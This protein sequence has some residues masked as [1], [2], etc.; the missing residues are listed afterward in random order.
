MKIP[1]SPPYINNNVIKEIKEAL[2]SGWITTGPKVKK[3]EEL[4]CHYT[5]APNAL[6]VNS[7]TSGLMLALKWFGIGEGDEVII[8]AYTYAATALAVIHVGATP[9][10]VDIEDDFNISLKGIK[11]AITEDTKAIIPVDIAGW[12]CDYDAINK[13]VDNTR[14]LFHPSHENQEKLGRIVVIADA[15]HA[16]GA[17]YKNKCIGATTDI[18]VFSF[19]AVK[20]VTTAEGGAIC[21]NLPEPFN[22]QEEYLFLRCFSLNGQTKDAFTKSKAGGWRYDIIYPGLK[23]N[24]PDL[25]AAVGVAQLPEYFES[26]LDRR[27]EIFTWYQEYFSSKTWAILPPFQNE[28]KTSSCHLYALRIKNASETQRDIIIDK[29]SKEGVSVNVHFQP[30][31]LL[32]LFKSYGYKI[33]DYPNA[34]NNYKA[35]IS[36]PIYPQLTGKELQYIVSTI[37]NAVESTL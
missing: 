9:I 30:L 13:L 26:V 14:D 31:P 10:M 15:A 36:L 29:I 27:K 11:D 4:V 3:L 18:T 2:D 19:H 24:L 7:A 32:S 37:T 23:M 12:P 33:E 5:K 34:F 35:E 22:N 8:P 1:F 6:G 20:N 16:I 21:L 17:E 28:E 25:L